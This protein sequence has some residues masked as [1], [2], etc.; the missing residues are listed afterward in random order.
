VVGKEL[1]AVI[2]ILE[3]SKTAP[4]RNQLAWIKIPA[5]KVLVITF[6]A[7]SFPFP[8]IHPIISQSKTPINAKL[9]KF[10]IIFQIFQR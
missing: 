6:F 5:I 1:T 4:I 7:S 10:F 3:I 8:V 2:A 9:A